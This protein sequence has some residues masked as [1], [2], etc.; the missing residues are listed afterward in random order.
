MWRPRYRPNTHVGQPQGFKVTPQGLLLT[1]R[2]R[3]PHPWKRG[4]FGA[5][6][7]RMH[8]RWRLEGREWD[9]GHRVGVSPGSGPRAGSP[10]VV[11]IHKVPTLERL[12]PREQCAPRHPPPSKT[13][14]DM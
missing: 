11:R 7:A 12:D 10:S 2:A 3:G 6:R 14:Q 8:Q 13:P 9:V 5:P 1:P 4:A